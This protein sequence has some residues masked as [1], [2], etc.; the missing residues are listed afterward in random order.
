MN[1]EFKIRFTG[2]FGDCL[3]MLTEQTSLYNEYSKSGILIHWVYSD[4]NLVDMVYKQFNGSK[5]LNGQWSYIRDYDIIDYNTGSNVSISGGYPIH[6]ALYDFLKH[7]PFFKL[8]SQHDYANA[9]LPELDNYRVNGYPEYSHSSQLRR[10]YEQEQGGWEI[11][12]SD[13]YVDSLMKDCEHTFC[14]QLSGSNPAKNYNPENYVKLFKMIL[15]KYPSCKIFL[16]DRPNFKVDPSILFDPR[17]INLVGKVSIIQCA[18][19]IQR[20]DYLICPD[21]YSKYLRKWVNKKQV[22]LCTRLD[23]HPDVNMMLQ[24]AF[25]IVGLLDNKDIK[26]LGVTY[27]IQ[28]NIVSNA[29][30][31]NSMND[32]SPKQVFEAITQ[33]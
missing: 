21:S 25:H 31:V 23:C 10:L 24:D 6:Q 15:N 12:I 11:K 4:M 17:I 9:D 5:I 32:I 33:L 1:K 19:L 22:I 8:I 13:G 28:N 29:K 7:F 26:L 2:G 16:I 3:K 27:N 14:V 30:I 20:V 18:I